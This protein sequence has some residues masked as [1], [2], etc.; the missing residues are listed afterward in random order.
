MNILKMFCYT[1]LPSTFDGFVEYTLLK[2]GL[3]SSWDV[4]KLKTTLK[5]KFGNSIEISKDN[6]VLDYKAYSFAVYIKDCTKKDV[7]LL[8]K[9]LNLF[10]YYIYKQDFKNVAEPYIH[11]MFSI[12]PKYPIIINDILIQKKITDLYHITHKSNLEKIKKYGLAPRGSETT[13]YHPDD[14]IYLIFTPSI[15]IL[16]GLK[17]V[18]ATDKNV[19]SD[20]MIIFKTTFNNSYNYYLDD[21]TTML[22]HGIYACFVLKNIRPEQ[23]TIIE[24]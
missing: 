1:K 10:G 12:E 11:R 13:F 16:Q 14:R 17:I 4:N 19:N 6:G 8:E 9:Q 7:D 21:L 15:D 2:E 24:V 5:N 22:K 23:L 18:L 3:I 20:D